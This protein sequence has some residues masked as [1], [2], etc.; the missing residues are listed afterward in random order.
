[1]IGALAVVGCEESNVSQPAFTAL[2]SEVTGLDFENEVVATDSFNVFNYMYFYNGGGVATGDFDGDSLPDLYFTNNMGANKLFLNRGAFQFEDVTEVAGVAGQGGWTSGVTVVDINNDG[3]LDLYV[4]QIGEYEILKGHNQLYVNLGNN[5]DGIPTFAERAADYGLD[6]VGFSTQ[7][8]FFDYDGDGDLDMFQLNHSLHQ[9]GTFGRK[10][11]FEGTYHPLSGDKLLR[12]DGGQ[13]VDVTAESGI[14]STVIGY[15]LGLATADLNQD[16]WPDIYIGNDFHEDDYLYLNQQDGTFKEVRKA[17]LMHTSRFSMG[18]DIADVNN[19]GLNDIFTLDMLPEDPYILKTSLGEDGYNQYKMKIGF[20]YEHQFAR[21][22]LQLNNGNGT[23]SE[24]GMYAGVFASDWSW[25]TL[26]MDFDHDGHKDI[27]ISNGI[28]R[29]MNDIDYMNFRLSDE[30]INFKTENNV[31]SNDEVQ[32]IVEKMPQIKLPNKF[33]RNSGQLTFEDL[34]SR[35]A[36]DQSTFSNGA[37]YADFDGDGD[38]DIVVNNLM[39]A[40]TMYRN[41]LDTS[42][43]DFLRIRLTGTAQ[44]RHGIGAKA[45]VYRGSERLIAEHFPTRGYQSAMLTDLHLGIGDASS[46]DSIVL[47]WP[48]RT[49]Q[50]LP[51]AFNRTQ[52]ATW[53]AGLPLFDFSS[54]SANAQP[55]A[56]LD[57]TDITAQ[58]GIDFT[59]EEN[60]FVEF[61]R[62][63]LIPHMMSSEGPAVAVGD[64]NGDGRE[65]VFLGSSKFTRSALYLQQAGGRFQLATPALILADSI[66]EDVDAAFIDIDNDG[67]LDLAI[68]AGGNEYIGESEPLRQRIYLNNGGGQFTEKYYLPDAYLTASCL[69]PQDVNGD[70]YV[71]IFIGGRSVPSHYGQRPRSYLFLNQQDGTFKD[72]TADWS[73]DLAQAGLVKDGAWYDMDGD[74]D[75]DLVLALEW[76]APR[77]YENT[78]KALVGHDIG[79]RRGWWNMVQPGDFDGDGDVD[80]IAGNFGENSRLR[81]TD[82]EPVRMYLND[83][84][85]NNKA[86]QVITYY[87]GGREVP[88]ANHSELMMQMPTLKKRYIYAKDLAEAPLTSIFGKQKLDESGHF[89]INTLQSC[90]FENLNDTAY[91]VQPLPQRLQWSTIEAAAPIEVAGKPAL[92]L[93]GNFYDC[94]IEMGRYDNNFGNLLT[95]GE[96][97]QATSLGRLAIKGQVRRI[98]PININGRTAYLFVKNDAAVQVIAPALPLQ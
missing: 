71:D 38:L 43:G 93:G 68:A 46:V 98:R 1:M 31:L 73:T 29:R 59:H 66:F 94:N 33:F 22:N 62:E 85:D 23:F 67:D 13:Y 72:A 64:V 96:S 83:F 75:A 48:D 51:L 52:V 4:S 50:H 18:V 2:T 5:A 45:I 56:P 77:W 84:D 7:A 28:P 35:I 41:E 53:R 70:G 36:N 88:F 91:Y 55:A 92:L 9:N 63:R 44:N 19:D 90:Y 17:Q 87:L 57:F 76:R 58:T 3:L 24:I 65:D 95:F 81:P 34:K 25:A 86:E 39:D 97:L 6:L 60:P 37:V 82:E 27:F 26:L 47:V 80:L 10:K 40:P 69:L 30:D 21:N 49:A 16:G 42:G 79:D 12:N 20:G 14:N 78:G 32:D 74:G 89:S 11:E 61:N 15:G 8:A 54:L